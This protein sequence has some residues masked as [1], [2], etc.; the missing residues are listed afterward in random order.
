MEKCVIFYNKNKAKA[1]EILTEVKNFL[2]KN[3][4]EIL[5]PDEI[6]DAT[7]SVVIGGDGTLLRAAKKIIEKDGLPVLSLI[8]ISEPTR[9]Y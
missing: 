6:L 1:T 2:E 3:H 5:T 7:F 4:V 8:H 9:P